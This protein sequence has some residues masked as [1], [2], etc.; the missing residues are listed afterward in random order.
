MKNK[1]KKKK[2]KKKKQNK[3]TQEKTKKKKTKNKKKEEE[4]GEAE[5]EESHHVPCWR[6]TCRGGR[7][8]CLSRSASG[9]CS[10]GVVFF[11]SCQDPWL[12]SAT[13]GGQPEEEGKDSVP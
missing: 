8:T 3:K 6:G 5:Q 13:A 12:L 9:G 7:A 10:I 4:E 11:Q 1:K 2:K